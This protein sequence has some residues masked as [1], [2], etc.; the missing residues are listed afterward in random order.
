[1]RSLAGNNGDLDALRR[2][3]EEYKDAHRD[4]PYAQCAR[5][6]NLVQDFVRGRLDFQWG[7]AVVFYD[8]PEKLT[9]DPEDRSTDMAPKALP[10]TLGALKRDLLVFS[11]YFVPGKHG[12]M[13][14]TDLGERGGWR[15]VC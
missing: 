10:K 7:H 1:M 11:P 14:L 15:F 13:M 12:V 2:E 4:S 5:S 3:L 6:S 9:T 8:L